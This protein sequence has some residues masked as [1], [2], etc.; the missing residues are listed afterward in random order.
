MGIKST[1]LRGAIN[2]LEL[3]E[4]ALNA[5]DNESWAYETSLIGNIIDTIY[6]VI[7]EDKDDGSSPI[8]V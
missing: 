2:Y 5:V 6:E 1:Q 7:Q 8:V 4:E 3:A